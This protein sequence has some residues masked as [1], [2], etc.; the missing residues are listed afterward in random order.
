VL[1]QLG[2]LKTYALFTFGGITAGTYAYGAGQSR[3]GKPKDH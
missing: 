3:G 1:T 2:E